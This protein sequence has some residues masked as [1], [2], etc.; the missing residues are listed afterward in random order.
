MKCCKTCGVEIPDNPKT[1]TRC[2][3]CQKNF[4]A[5]YRSAYKKEYYKL[6]YYKFE[7]WT[8]NN[9]N[10]NAFYAISTFVV[11]KSNSPIN[12]PVILN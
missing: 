1:R 3:S 7:D 4:E 12:K 5:E 8:N 11:V 2:A 10:G 6:V 9:G